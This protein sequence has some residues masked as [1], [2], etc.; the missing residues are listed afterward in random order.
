MNVVDL[1]VTMIDIE[2]TSG[3]EL[4]MAEFLESYMAPKGWEVVRQTYAPGRDNVYMHRPGKQPRLLFNSHID[5]VPPFF[6]A[7]KDDTWIYGRGACDTKSLIA[8]QLLA[9]ED[10]VAEGRDDIGLLYVVGEE[11][12]HC[13]MIKANELNLDPDFLIVGEPTESKLVRRQKGLVKARLEARGKA[14]HSGYPETGVSAVEKILDILE[15]LRKEPW[16]EESSLGKT[17][18]NIGLLGGGRAANIVPDKAF[19]EVMFRVVTSEKEIFARLKAIVAERAEVDLITSND[20]CDLGTVEG[21]E[22]VVVSFNT[23]IPYFKFN[24]KALLWGAGSILDAHTS[25]EKIR[26]TDLEKAVAVYAEL[27]RK[28]L[29]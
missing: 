10:L 15:D 26:I 2:S 18:M 8:A 5:T 20:P 11:V 23:D 28:C 19:A 12:D 3:A 29:A 25:G 17:T 21:Y 16:P 13:G 24:G 6:P 14:A 1:A 22:T 9:A 7:S 4:P 27:A